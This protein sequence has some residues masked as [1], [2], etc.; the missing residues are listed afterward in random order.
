MLDLMIKLGPDGTLPKWSDPQG[1]CYCADAGLDIHSAGLVVIPPG[2]RRRVPTDMFTCFSPR[3]GVLLRDRS[4]LAFR[5]GI[6]VIAGVIDSSYRG[7]WGIVLLN[8]GNQDVT[9]KKGDRIVQAI[10][11]QVYHPTIVKVNELPVSARGEA[12]FGSSGR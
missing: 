12:G 1:H 2:E 7:E 11:I 6:T 4:G 8:T 5:Q 9:I 3:Y 10:F